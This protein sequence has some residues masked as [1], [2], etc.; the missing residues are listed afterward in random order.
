MSIPLQILYIGG[1]ALIFF[2]PSDGDTLLVRALS[3][4]IV[5]FITWIGQLLFNVIYLFSS[6]KGTLF[7]RRIIELQDDALLQETRFNKSYHYWP[8]I[9][10]VVKRPGYVAVYVNTHA[11]YV[12]PGRA[13]VDV[14]QRAEF[15]DTLRNKILLAG[16][17][18]V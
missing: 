4:V 6:R 2:M 9:L 17:T 18:P 8:G 15:V 14:E 13:F 5:Y 10:K 1:A 12:I 3:A 16:K 7:A 11:A